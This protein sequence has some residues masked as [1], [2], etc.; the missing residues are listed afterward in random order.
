MAKKINIKGPVVSNGSMWIYQYLGWDACCPA[1]LEQE[2]KEADGDEVILEINSYGGVAMSGFEM[3]KMLLDYGGKI[4]AHVIN[5]MSA[6]SVIMCAA[7]EVLVS[8]AA[9]IM[10]HNTQSYGEGD[11]R[12]MQMEAD[13]LREYDESLLNVYERRTGLSRDKLRDMMDHDTHMSPARAIEYGFADGY[14][15]GDPSKKNKKG[16]D[17]GKQGAAF[18]AAAWQTV[19][20]AAVPVIS[21]ERAAELRIAIMKEEKKENTGGTGSQY[22]GNEND[23]E[24]AAAAG[25]ERKENEE[26]T[27]EEFLKENKDAKAQVDAMITAAREEGVKEAEAKEKASGEEAMAAAREEGAENERKR[28]CELDKLAHSVS[29]EVLND[30]KYGEKRMDARDLAFQAMQDE[31]LRAAGYMDQA[32]KDAKDSGTEDVGTGS[33]KPDEADTMA[34]HVNNGRQKKGVK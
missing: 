30:A 1:K 15:Y 19:M 6:A 13:A 18:N 27:L 32:K 14:L 12:D 16:A 8:D 23:P 26:M 10:I 4:T 21:E 9:I 11:R 2:L 25:T 3:Y 34:S 24:K 28:L 7:D 29:A 22:T 31:K 17:A 33:G 20:A 5:A